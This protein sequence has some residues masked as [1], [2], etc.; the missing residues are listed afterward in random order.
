MKLSPEQLEWIVREV[1]RRL[2]STVVASPL[3]RMTTPLTTP[4]TARLA[5]AD[6][7]VT[8]ETLRNQLEGITHVDVTARAVVTPAVVDLLRD[9]QITLVRLASH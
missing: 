2:Q 4:I 8:T 9:Q 7:L 5:I 3:M 1:V 6:R